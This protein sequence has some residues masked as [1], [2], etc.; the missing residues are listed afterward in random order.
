MQEK[1]S[2]NQVVAEKLEP[3]DQ[4]LNF[5]PLPLRHVSAL[6]MEKIKIYLL[7]G[8]KY[9]LYKNTGLGFNWTDRDRLLETGIE[10]VYILDKDF[11]KHSAELEDSIDD[12]IQDKKIALQTRVKIL[13][14]YTVAFASSVLSK[15]IN[16]DTLDSILKHTRKIIGTLGLE[17][18]AMKHLIN[19]TNHKDNSIAVHMA[20]NCTL[21]MCFALKAGLTEKRTLA[22]V[23]AGAMLQDIGKTLLPPELLACT[24]K[25]EESQREIFEN[26]VKLSLEQLA[27]IDNL[28]EEIMD[29]VSCHHERYD[30]SGYP[31][32]LQGDRIPLMGQAAGLVE[33]FEAM[34]SARPY[35][36]QPMTVKQAIHEIDVN[37]KDKFDKDLLQCFS[38]F[39]KYHLMGVSFIPEEELINYEI[40]SMRVLDKSANPSGRRHEREYFRC[41]AKVKSLSYMQDQWVSDDIQIVTIYNI[42]RSGIGF[43]S[44]LPFPENKLIQVVIH[45]NGDV[46][47]FLAKC[48]RCNQQNREWY[49]I[50]AKFL[51]T[52]TRAEFRA[53]VEKMGDTARSMGYRS[54]H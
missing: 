9:N 7:T 18:D 36:K 15:P 34:I 35:R 46:L 6:V 1:T 48:V 50:G 26:H 41:P 10:F 31:K 25:L 12:T 11:V 38:G 23:G 29:I 19:A 43:L 4:E 3:E 54:F 39:V 37:M 24:D 49:A 22:T 51:R 27:Q 40:A 42:S 32:K 8:N 2:D 52:F 45:A 33:C 13:Y 14:E 20:N 30:G 47:P 28:D 44:H 17:V 21:L 53:I 5:I 16:N